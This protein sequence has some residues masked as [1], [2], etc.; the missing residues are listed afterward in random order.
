[1]ARWLAPAPGQA[2]ADHLYL[3]DP[4]GEWMMRAPVDADPMRLKRDLE[5]LLRASASWQ[6]AGS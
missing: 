4:M 1:V 3:V 5:R 6:R 2:L